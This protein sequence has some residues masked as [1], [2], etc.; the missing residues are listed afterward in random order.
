MKPNV[1]VAK[2]FLFIFSPAIPEGKYSPLV[3]LHW[4]Q[5]CNY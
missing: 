5:I 4:T 1:H 2:A 3:L